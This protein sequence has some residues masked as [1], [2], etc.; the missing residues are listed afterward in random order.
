VPSG[1][2]S[3]GGA[4]LAPVWWAVPVRPFLRPVATAVVV[5]TVLALAGCDS[6]SPGAVPVTPTD[7]ARRAADV[8]ARLADEDLAGQ[9]LMPYAYGHHATEVSAGSRAG[10]QKLGKVDTP[11]QLIAKYRLGALVLVSFSGDDPTGKTNPTTNVDSAG[12]VRVLTDGLQQAARQLPAAVPLLVGVDQEYG[13]VTRIRSGMVQLPG[14]MALAAAGRPELTEAAWR[15]AGTELAAAG[16]TVD[17]APVADVLGPAGSQVVGSRSYG[18]DPTAVSA[19]VSAAVRGLRAGGVAAT[20]KH[21]PG[22]GHVS[23]DSHTTLPVLTQ[24]RAALESG[25]LPPF[26]AGIQAGAELVMSGWLDTRAIEPGVAAAFSRKV[27][28]D[29]L[30]GELGFQGVVV[31]DALNMEPAKRYPPGEAAWRALAAGND[32][33]LMPPDLDAAYQGILGAVRDGKLPRERLVEAVT[34]ILT[35]KYRLDRPKPDVSTLDNAD[36]VAAARAVAAAAVTV[37]KGPCH[38]PLLS[39]PVRVTTSNGR[40][41]QRKWLAEA[42]RRAGVQVVDQ[43]GSVVHLVGYRDTVPDLAKDAAMT[44]AM[45][46]PGLLG[47]AGSGIRVATYSSTRVAMEALAD[48]IAGKAGAP[49]R[50]PVDVPGLPRT[51]CA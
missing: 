31:T 33:L 45:D 9:V 38:G 28:V 22:H 30:R 1:W 48:V 3:P 27:L 47:Q 32:L 44:V 39:G 35:L 34:R 25:D 49:G 51:A 24:N 12:Q 43:G 8:V 26:R 23:A 20:L 16:V 14:P 15:A 17:F 50:S 2:H 37:L 5:A 10:N 18:M 6:S 40:D 7:P 19:Q 29:L 4:R 11:A 13:P 21:F 46:T 42:L 41:T 36:H